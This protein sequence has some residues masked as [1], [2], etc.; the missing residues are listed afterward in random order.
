MPTSMHHPPDMSRN[1]SLQ[2]HIRQ[3]YSSSHDETSDT[4]ALCEEDV[5]TQ[6]RLVDLLIL[7]IIYEN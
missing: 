5:E 7:L 2:N 1:L 3:K 4:S 6:N